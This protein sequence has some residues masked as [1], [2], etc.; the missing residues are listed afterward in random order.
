MSDN[1]RAAWEDRNNPVRFALERALELAE[2]GIPC[3]PCLANKK[4]ACVH[5]FKQATAVADDLR[6]LWGTS[7]GVLVGVPTGTPSGLFVVDIDSARHPEAKVWHE[8]NAPYLPQTRCHQTE[9]GGWH[10]FFQHREGLRNSG[11]KLARGVDTRGSGG[12][13]IWWPAHLGGAAQHRFAVATPIPDWIVD[14]LNPP[15][16]A[17][18]SYYGA[19]Y[20]SNQ[21]TAPN[22]LEG[23]LTRVAEAKEGERNQLTFWGA[24]KIAD[25]IALRELDAHDATNAIEA[26]TEVS[27]RTGLQLR[28]IRRTIASAMR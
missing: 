3:F 10:L 19:P 13:C 6:K 28:E 20:Y 21:A 26:L 23:I 17:I 24:C 7:P 5:G 8:Q 1:E 18:I 11:S 14:A 16:P 25:M 15:P 22:R 12:Y 9:S 27:L 4:P 2:Q